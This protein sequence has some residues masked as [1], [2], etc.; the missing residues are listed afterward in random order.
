MFKIKK[1]NVLIDITEKP[2][3]VKKEESGIIS[4]TH[5]KNEAWGIVI[6]GIPYNVLNGPSRFS[7]SEAETVSI[8]EF[9]LNNSI[10]KLT[11][12]GMI[13][14]NQIDNLNSAIK[15]AKQVIAELEGAIVDLDP[16]GVE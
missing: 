13:A 12:L 6:D 7:N 2:V 16:E 4:I 15:E 9:E 11:S 14:E 5:D 8:K 1:G 3:F 10:A